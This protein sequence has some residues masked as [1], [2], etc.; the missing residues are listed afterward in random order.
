VRQRRLYEDRVTGSERGSRAGRSVSSRS[1]MVGRLTVVHAI[2][3]PNS[4]TS[5]GPGPTN[6]NGVVQM[7]TPLKTGN[8]ADEMIE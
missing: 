8:H 2:V 6:I 7:T 1:L 3:S 4:W 5:A